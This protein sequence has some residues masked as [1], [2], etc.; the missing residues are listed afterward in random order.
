[1]HWVVCFFDLR[2]FV[3]GDMRKTFDEVNNVQ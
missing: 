2:E 3:D 1:M